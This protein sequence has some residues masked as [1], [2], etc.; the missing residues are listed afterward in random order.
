MKSFSQ[1]NQDII[2]NDLFFKNKENG[3]FV[4]IGAYDG[5]EKSNTYAYET[6]LNWTGI[7]VEPIADRFDELSKNRQC[8]CIHGVVSDKDQDT[9][10]FCEIEGYSEM[11]SGILEDY[12]ENHKRRIINEG[13]NRK[14][15]QYKNYRINDIL[16]Q[17]KITKIDLLDIDTEG[18]ELKILKDIDFEIVDVDVI[19]VECNY[20]N[21]EMKKFLEEK[22]YKHVTSIGADLVFK[23]I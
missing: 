7:C 14:K 3:V 11:L 18:N 23:K 17:N 8:I 12:D 19:L 16:K 2:L 4:D 1:Y 6:V 22:Q 20:D 21:S 10:E 15:V 5:I 13:G 9:V